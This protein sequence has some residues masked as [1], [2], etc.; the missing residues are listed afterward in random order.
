MKTNDVVSVYVG[1][2]EGRGGK[3]RPVLV[4]KVFTNSVEVFKITSKY[5]NKSPYIQQQYYPIEDWKVVGLNRKS[6]VDLGKILSIPTAGITFKS[7]G[8]LTKLDQIKIDLFQTQ[9]NKIRKNNIK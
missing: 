7:I 2:V 8:K 5:A 3:T 6:W 9:L 4:R 1:Y